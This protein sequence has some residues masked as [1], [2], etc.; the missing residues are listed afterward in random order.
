MV[1]ECPQRMQRQYK[2]AQVEWE[3]GPETG[4]ETEMHEIQ[5]GKTQSQV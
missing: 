1:Y 2:A 4:A 5:T 3:Y